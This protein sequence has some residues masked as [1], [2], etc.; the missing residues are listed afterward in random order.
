VGAP[1][2]FWVLIAALQGISFKFSN[3]QAGFHN[4]TKNPEALPLFKDQI[5]ILNQLEKKSNQSTCL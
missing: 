4:K 1:M 5:Q 3:F 2:L